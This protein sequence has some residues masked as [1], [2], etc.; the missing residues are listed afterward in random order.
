MPLSPLVEYLVGHNEGLVNNQTKNRPTLRINLGRQ[1]ICANHQL[2]WSLLTET[3][4]NELDSYQP[5]TYMYIY[6][7][8]ML[9]KGN[10]SKGIDSC[11][12]IMISG[13]SEL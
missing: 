3:F 7:T 8:F 11:M 2:D 4:F 5:G 12:N 1:A 9:A 13:A 6:D 10:L